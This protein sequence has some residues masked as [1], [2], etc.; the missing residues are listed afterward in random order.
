[1]YRG[2]R[3]PGGLIWLPFGAVARSSPGRPEESR[4]DFPGRC[5]ADDL[6]A[7]CAQRRS[8]VRVE[9]PLERLLARL[10]E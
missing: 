10:P 3:T 9:V 1:V 5:W 2:R 7:K 6:R 4:V 8:D